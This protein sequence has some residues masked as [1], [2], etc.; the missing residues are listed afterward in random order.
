M[1]LV[2]VVLPRVGGERIDGAAAG[3]LLAGSG[4]PALADGGGT[5]VLAAEIAGALE[6]RAALRAGFEVAFE[7]ALARGRRSGREGTDPVAA[8]EGL[9]ER[10]DARV[11]VLVVDG[12]R[13]VPERGAELARALRGEDDPGRGL[14]T[15]GALLLGKRGEGVAELGGDGQRGS[16]GLDGVHRLDRLAA[17]STTVGRAR[18]GGHAGLGGHARV[19]SRGGR[20]LARERR[21]RKERDE[22]R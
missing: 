9:V 11:D 10:G 17:A 8:L 21:E 5:E 1:A 13:M 12:K 20:L 2:D 6:G 15:C 18:V 19:R 14:A 16:V 4:Q 3:G 7:D 22:R